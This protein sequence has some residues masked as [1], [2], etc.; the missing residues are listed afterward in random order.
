V[1]A[2]GVLLTVLPGCGGSGAVDPDRCQSFLRFSVITNQM[3]KTNVRVGNVRPADP[4][5]NEQTQLLMLSNEFRSASYSYGSLA[6]LASEQ[7][8]RH[9][10]WR[11][12]ERLLALQAD[13]ADDLATALY[14]DPGGDEKSWARLNK[15]LD[16]LTERAEKEQEPLIDE[17]LRRMTVAFR[18]EGFEERRDGG[19]VVKC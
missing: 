11:T 12:L 9:L 14:D 3:N 1:L 15:A 18:A 5:A 16:R 6:R 8:G 10:P 4:E 19:F 2:I 17:V 7:R 13:W